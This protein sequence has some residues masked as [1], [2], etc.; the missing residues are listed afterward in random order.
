MSEKKEFSIKIVDGDKESVLVGETYVVV[1]ADANGQTDDICAINGIGT[2]E[3][4]SACVACGVEQL[5]DNGIPM[6]E[7]IAHIAKTTSI[8][9]KTAIE[10][11]KGGTTSEQ[12]ATDAH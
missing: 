9:I 8:G 7:A 4:I 3:L 10:S 1:V 2:L 11:Q 12:V 6:H 5:L